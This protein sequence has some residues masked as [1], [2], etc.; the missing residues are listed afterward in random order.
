MFRVLALGVIVVIAVAALMLFVVFM[1]RAVLDRRD[2]RDE[3]RRM[4]A[5]PSVHEGPVAW[6][7]WAAYY[8]GLAE[9]ARAEGNAGSATTY[10]S[11][12]ETYRMLASDAP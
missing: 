7:Q 10:D 5:R 1:T 8:R 4:R 12:A 9:Q 2:R 11:L 6:R 3:Q